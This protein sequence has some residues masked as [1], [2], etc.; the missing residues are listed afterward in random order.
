MTAAAARLGASPYLRARARISRA[1]PAYTFERIDKLS[2]ARVADL[3]A[4]ADWL[5]AKKE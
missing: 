3:V 2:P 5:D 1:F 4:A